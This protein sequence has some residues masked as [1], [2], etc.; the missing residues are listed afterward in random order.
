M[1]PS[2]AQTTSAA[3]SL[4][5][6]KRPSIQPFTPPPTAPI[7]V[8]RLATIVVEIGL[9]GLNDLD[10]I[11]TAI[12]TVLAEGIGAVFNTNTQTTATCTIGLNQGLNRRL[13]KMELFKDLYEKPIL[14]TVA[15]TFDDVRVAPR[16]F[17]FADFLEDLIVSEASLDFNS[18][19][20]LRWVPASK[21][22]TSAWWKQKTSQSWLSHLGTLQ[23]RVLQLHQLQPAVAGPQPQKLITF[24]ALDIFCLWWLL[25]ASSRWYN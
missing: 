22:S 25:L 6:S 13:Q 10:K 3:P 17:G 16:Q 8:Q 7:P 14:I 9:D 12:E 24:M 23:L 19:S 1:T 5:P 21:M 11:C 15:T 20:R 18:N 4:A 2:I